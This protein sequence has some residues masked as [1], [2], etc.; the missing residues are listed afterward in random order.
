MVDKG[1]GEKFGRN[2]YIEGFKKWHFC[3]AKTNFDILTL[4]L[5][6]YLYIIYVFIWLLYY[7]YLDYYIYI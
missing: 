6:I 1:H 2:M 4:I 7:F 3:Y 5:C